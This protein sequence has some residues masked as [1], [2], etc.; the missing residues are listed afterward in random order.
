MSAQVGEMG[1]QAG[2]LAQTAAALQALVERFV[3]AA[4]QEAI[5]M[6]DPFPLAA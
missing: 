3:L 5:A 2:Q 1:Q 6:P 4:S